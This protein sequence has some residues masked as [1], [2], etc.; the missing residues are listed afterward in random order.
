[1]NRVRHLF[2]ADRGGR[3]G[4]GGRGKTDNAPLRRLLSPVTATTAACVAD[5]I[6]ETLGSVLVDDAA[7]VVVPVG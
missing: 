2:A 1:M 3:L 6:D 5:S 7:L 4:V